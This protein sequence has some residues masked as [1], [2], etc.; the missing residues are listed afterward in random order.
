MTKY[1]KALL[2]LWA[3]YRTAEDADDEQKLEELER[4]E[5]EV[6]KMPMLAGYTA[7]EAAEQ[8]QEA[9]D[10]FHKKTNPL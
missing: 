5:E 7:H 10:H 4:R 3:D 9:V 2:K 8:Y 1:Q 6:R